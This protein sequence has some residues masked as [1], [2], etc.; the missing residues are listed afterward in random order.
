MSDEGII[1]LVVDDE[2]EHADGIVEARAATT[3]HAGDALAAPDGFGI[4]LLCQ[5]VGRLHGESPRAVIEAVN[6][7]VRRY[8]AP[9]APHDDRTMIALRYLGVT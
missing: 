4:E 9:A 7:D 2:R 5:V 1:V 8:C 6:E 3:R